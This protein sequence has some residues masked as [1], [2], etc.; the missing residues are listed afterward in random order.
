MS[1]MIIITSAVA[2]LITTTVMHYEVLRL[3]SSTLAQL[4]ILPRAKVMIVIFVTFSAHAIEIL[5]YGVAYYFLTRVAGLGAVGSHLPR[6]ATCIY[7]SAETFTSL[8]FGDVVPQGPVRFLAGAECLNGLLLIGWSASFTY[9]C[10]ER[11]WRE[12]E[13]Q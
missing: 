9:I 3:L 1:S 8:G 12:H 11:F 2:L 13:D 6:L 10:M 7:L 4:R 5:F